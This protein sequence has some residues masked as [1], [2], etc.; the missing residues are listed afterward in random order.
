MAV[1][2]AL[3]ATGAAA[4]SA[5]AAAVDLGTASSFAVL[6]AT[7]VTNTGPS[8]VSGDLGVSPGTAIVGFPPGTLT[9]GAFHAANAT[10]ATAQTNVTTAYNDAAGRISSATVSGDLAGRTLTPGVYTSA[11]SLSLSGD[12]TLNAGGNP[13]ATF[14]F[15]AGSTLIAGSG[16]RVLLIGGAQACNVVWQLGSSATVGTASAFVGDILAMTSITMNT[17]ATLDGRALGRNGAVTLDTNTMTRSACASA[18]TP[19]PPG[20]TPTPTPTPPGVTPTPPGGTPGGT[21]ND[22]IRATLRRRVVT[23][24]RAAERLRCT[25]ARLRGTVR[26]RATATSYHFQFGT[27]RAYGRVTNAGVVARGTRMVPVFAQA[28]TLKP[29]RTYHYRLVGVSSTGVRTMGANGTFSTR[30]WSTCR[31]SSPARPTRTDR[32]LTG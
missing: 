22:S 9:G 21:P 1:C 2:V 17:G 5:Q 12:L 19:T 3:A 18:V 4:G 6:G 24:T 15:Q 30:A 14:V 29:N 27:T 23:T 25:T 26:R 7:T 20:T 32:G 8:V 28:S 31:A 13:D 10:A 11:S 16:S